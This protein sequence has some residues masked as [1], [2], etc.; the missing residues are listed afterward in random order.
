LILRQEHHEEGPAT[1]SLLPSLPASRHS[2]HGP[3]ARAPALWRVREQKR[4]K[5]GREGGVV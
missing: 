2:L 4:P 5:G 1:S 3:G